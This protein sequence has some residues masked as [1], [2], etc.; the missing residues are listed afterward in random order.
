MI[1]GRFFSKYRVTVF[2]QTNKANCTGQIFR[3][4]DKR[5]HKVINSDVITQWQKEAKELFE[6]AYD[7]SITVMIIDTFIQVY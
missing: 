1:K 5:K 7:I 2:Y 3:I 6:K 4:V